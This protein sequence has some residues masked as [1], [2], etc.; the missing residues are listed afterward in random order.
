[1]LTL[2]LGFT[3]FPSYF[4]AHNVNFRPSAPLG[5]VAL[6]I[7]HEAFIWLRCMLYYMKLADYKTMQ[8]CKEL[9]SFSL[10]E[11]DS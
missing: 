6:S 9:T 8:F 4:S 10:L 11:L 2:L 7:L 3:P 1:M 5:T